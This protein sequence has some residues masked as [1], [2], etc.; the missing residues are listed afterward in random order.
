MLSSGQQ[1]V[2]AVKAC[3]ETAENLR[4]QRDFLAISSGL[5]EGRPFWELLSEI[6]YLDPLLINMARVGEETG[7]LPQ[8]LAKCEQYFE[9]MQAYTIRRMNKLIEPAITI[10]LGVLLGI[11]MLSVILPAFSLTEII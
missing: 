9:Y 1:L 4:V 2:G 10:V 6:K 7:R 5:A 8:S 3:A 11:V